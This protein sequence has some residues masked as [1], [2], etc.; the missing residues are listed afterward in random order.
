VVVSA[1]VSTRLLYHLD[2][3]RLFL[4]AG[5]ACDVNLLHDQL[6]VTGVGVVTRAPAVWLGPILALGV[7]L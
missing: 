7:N 5:V 2:L 1:A 3:G 4:A 6:G